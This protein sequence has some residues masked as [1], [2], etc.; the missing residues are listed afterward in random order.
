MITSADNTLEGIDTPDATDSPARLASP[1]P[2]FTRRQV[3]V[4]LGATAAVAATG[5]VVPV[6]GGGSLPAAEAAVISPLTQIEPGGRAPGIVV[7]VTL[8]GGND[9]LDTVVPYSN[10]A[11]QSGRGSLAVA[12]DR[13]LPLDAEFGFH[14]AMTAFKKLWD[15]R[16]LAIVRGVGY[17]NPN[18]SHFRS[19]DIWQS[20]VPDRAEISGWLGRWQDATSSDPLRMLSLGASVPRALIGL[21]GGGGSALPNGQVALPG[22][23]GITNAFVELGR[24]SAGA[25][26]GPWGARIGATVGNLVRVV[27]QLG[28]ILKAGT[29]TAETA[30]L[31]GGSSANGD[32]GSVLDSQLNDVA[33]LIKGDAPTRVY[34]VSL[35][36]FD[37]HANEGDQHARLLAAVDGAIGRFL[38]SLANEPKASGVTLLV[39]SEFGRR[40]AANLSQGTDHGTAA[41]IFV[42]GPGVKGGFYGDAPSLTDLDQ[43]D[44]KFTTDFRSVYAT[45]LGGVLGVDPSV[46]LSGTWAPLPLLR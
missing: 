31:E 46:T 23:K 34:S 22:G 35:G 14:P 7:L 30:S 16:K 40:V 38:V 1:S 32:S 33:T 42:I 44:L 5:M 4:G 36:G 21:K 19:M 28:P 2:D 3:L 11:Y 26:L 13:V 15:D 10:S 37:T 9:G 20:G 17:P 25:E 18:R 24:G 8:Y 6:R 45:I 12:A 29:K 39:Y 27:D 43:G 41:P